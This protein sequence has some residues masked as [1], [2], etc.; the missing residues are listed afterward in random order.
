MAVG[1][2]CFRYQSATEV[3]ADL[4]AGLAALGAPYGPKEALDE[5]LISLTGA[6]MSRG[7]LGPT[8]ENQLPPNMVTEE[9]IINERGGTTSLPAAPSL[10]LPAGP[11][12]ASA[13]PRGSPD[14]PARRRGTAN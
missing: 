3:E 13:A 1:L 4:R 9:D 11:A 12:S 7:V 6:S 8:S 5:V 14:W 2:E 10:T